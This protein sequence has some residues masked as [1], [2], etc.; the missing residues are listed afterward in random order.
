MPRYK[1]S[2]DAAAAA[3]FVVG[4]VKEKRIDLGVDELVEP[5]AHTNTN[6][7]R[8]SKSIVIARRGAFPMLRCSPKTGS[9]FVPVSSAPLPAFLS[10]YYFAFIVLVKSLKQK[11]RKPMHITMLMPTNNP[12]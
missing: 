11:I 3:I 12:K 7:K 6:D 2:P 8:A 1:P 10:S 4:V 9:L 5:D